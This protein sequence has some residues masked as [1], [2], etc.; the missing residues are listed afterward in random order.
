MVTKSAGLRFVACILAALSLTDARRAALQYVS[1]PAAATGSVTEYTWHVTLSSQAPDCFQRNVLL[2]NG[3]FQPT[4]E[5][6][7]GDFLKVGI[8]GLR[9]Q[10]CSGL[11][12]TIIVCRQLPDAHAQLSTAKFEI[13][14]RHWHVFAVTA[15]LA[16][17]GAVVFAHYGQ[18][19]VYL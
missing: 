8:C 17:C 19:S 13:A 11:L 5:V 7:Q 18:I 15:C 14:T 3:S 4:L 12:F 9:Q 16:C 10:L 2:V 6:V 1:A